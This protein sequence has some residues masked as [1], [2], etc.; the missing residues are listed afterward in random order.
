[1]A[2]VLNTT[3]PQDRTGRLGSFSTYNSD[4]TASRD[5]DFQQSTPTTGFQPVQT[6]ASG[7]G[8]R[9]DDT[10]PPYGIR[11]TTRINALESTVQRMASDLSSSIEQIREVKELLLRLV[12]PSHH[13]PSVPT[14]VVFKSTLP[15]TAPTDM[16]SH[17][18]EVDNDEVV[19][20]S[21]TH[22]KTRGQPPERTDIQPGS[23]SWGSRDTIPVTP[24]TLLQSFS[25]KMPVGAAVS[26][27]VSASIGITSND[28]SPHPT[29]TTTPR[30]AMRRHVAS[31]SPSS[32]RL[33]ELPGAADL[34]STQDGV[35]TRG[36][37]SVTDRSPRPCGP[38]PT[39]ELTLPPRI[40]SNAIAANALCFILQL[41]HGNTIVA[42]GRAGG[43]WKSPSARLGSLCAEGQQMVQVHKIIVPNVPLVFTEDRHPFTTL[44]QALVKPSGSSVYVKWIS[45]LRYKKNKIL[46]QSKNSVD[47]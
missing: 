40:T 42:E 16:P 19:V 45:K 12:N 34:D 11:E 28:L 33:G 22:K 5:T 9:R 23:P 18:P 14:G 35:T 44:D 2:Q 27:D 21:S 6:C 20:A 4:S 24:N 47:R 32:P 8:P 3:P 29:T 46:P 13:V 30:S 25:N 10:T 38:R 43:S 41:D 36:M 17:I 15:E 39:V 26:T 31:S 37:A 1:M 7:Q